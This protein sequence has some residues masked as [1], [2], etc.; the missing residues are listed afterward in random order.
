MGTVQ[1]DSNTALLIAIFVFLPLFGMKTYS[2]P[3]S[4]SVRTRAWAQPGYSNYR[5]FLDFLW[6][7]NLVA[8]TV[9]MFLFVIDQQNFQQS[10]NKPQPPNPSM[11]TMFVVLFTLQ[12]AYV[13]GFKGLGWIYDL[14]KDV[15]EAK[16]T[17]YPF[18]SKTVST[19]LYNSRQGLQEYRGLNNTGRELTTDEKTRLK[20]LK[21]IYEQ[22]A[23]IQD[24]YVSKAMVATLLFFLF[25]VSLTLFSLYLWYYRTLGNNGGKIVNSY[26]VFFITTWSIITICTALEVA[27]G[28]WV[29]RFTEGKNAQNTA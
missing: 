29:T 8:L 18:K 27:L 15:P 12:I 2:F 28:I 22:V 24:D 19:Y 11:E 23:D 17:F 9:S 13:I 26:A 4:M 14:F 10:N 20:E 1:E 7:Y 16:L 25:V 3:E 21:P 6:G 5:K